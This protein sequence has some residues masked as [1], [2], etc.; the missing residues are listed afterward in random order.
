VSAPVVE[1]IDLVFSG[2][3]TLFPC[4]VGAYSA[5]VTG[6]RRPVRVAGTSG[7]ALVAAGVA[8]GM[9]PGT[10]L[11]LAKAA[12]GAGAYD[13]EPLMLFARG[14][15]VSP[16]ERIGRLLRKHFPGTMGE[17]ALP[18]K[19]LVVDVEERAPVVLDSTLTPNL[20]TADVVLASMAIPF[21]FRARKIP[22]VPGLFCDGGVAANFAMSVFDDAPHRRTVGIRF[23]GVTVRRPVSTIVEYAL[24][25]QATLV[26]NANRSYV[27]KKRYA[28]V[29]EVVSRGDSMDFTMTPADVQARFNEGHFTASDW[30]RRRT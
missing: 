11:D 24:A 15:G 6:G 16:A 17:A 13:A 30:L 12:L 21:A 2:S 1:D 4:H 10:M 26:D 8:H 19:A 7:G 27:S 9:E 28:D 22:G 3:G 29:I 25:V 20:P 18:W 5:L 14:W 23:R